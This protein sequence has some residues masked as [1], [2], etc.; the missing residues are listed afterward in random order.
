[1]DVSSTF[2]QYCFE[3][4]AHTRDS[5]EGETPD[6]EQPETKPQNHPIAMTELQRELGSVLRTRTKSM[7]CDIVG[8]DLDSEPGKKALNSVQKVKIHRWVLKI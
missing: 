7:D 1:M 2:P 5:G 6:H 8:A 4:D 3:M